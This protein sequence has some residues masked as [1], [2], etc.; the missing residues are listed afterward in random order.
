MTENRLV[1]TW[2]I[3]RRQFPHRHEESFESVGN[4]L[5]LECNYGF[6]CVCEREREIEC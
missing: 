4:V 5:Y 1:A 6:V 2:G 3:G